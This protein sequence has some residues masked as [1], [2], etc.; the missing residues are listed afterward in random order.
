[1]KRSWGASGV[2]QIGPGLSDQTKAH[3]RSSVFD[4]GHR[5]SCPEVFFAT[6]DEAAGI[7]RSNASLREESRPAAV[8]N[9]LKLALNAALR[10]N[11]RLDALDGNSRS[12]LVDVVPT[13]KGFEENQLS[14][15]DSRRPTGIM[16]LRGNLKPIIVALR[17]ALGRAKQYPKKGDLPRHHRLWLAADIA[18]AIRELLNIKLNKKP[19]DISKGVF[20]SILELVFNEVATGEKINLPKLARDALTLDV[21]SADQGPTE[22][23]PPRKSN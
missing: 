7:Y 19:K 17:E 14:D 11:D 8:R 10:L 15:P 18:D 6:L 3:I 2:G 16:L 22:Y 12:I 20:V 5:T 4:C 13:I 9:N 21:K 1:M 23:H